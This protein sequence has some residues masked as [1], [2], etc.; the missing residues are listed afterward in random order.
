MKKLLVISPSFPKDASESHVIPFLQHVFL[1]FKEQYQDVELT[2]VAI[3]KPLLEKPYDW[4]GIKIIP[5]QGND[6]K[7]PLK[8]VFLL[9]SFYKLHRLVKAN[10]YDG[11]LNLWHNEFS[12]F[13][14]VFRCKK[15]TWM[16]GQD[17]KKDNVYLRYFKP[18]PN[19]I[20]TLSNYNNEALYKSAAIRAHKIIPMAI[21]E[22]LFPPL[23]NE[24]RYIDVFGAG[25]LSPLKNYKFFLEIILA[26]K[27]IKPNIKAELAGMGEQEQ[28][29]KRFVAENNLED[30][31]TFLGMISHAATLDKMNHSKIFLHTSL[32]EGGS[33][34]YFEALY[35][36]CQLIGTLPMMDKPIENF[37]FHEIK[38]DIV[39]K[40]SVLLENLPPAKRVRYYSMDF[41]CKEIYDLYYKS[42]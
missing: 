5:L 30:N 6:I 23:N 4:N 2:I 35:S 24:Q 27:A 9:K 37:H 42:A 22:N 38:M 11:I 10:Q 17:V 18:N 13:T 8:V 25:F 19:K 36:G 29:L 3:H 15:F 33:T 12:V 1:A 28:D 21:N 32:F 26:L 40:I 20:M 16:L 14:Q 39:D 41:V 7:Y 34:V 31:V